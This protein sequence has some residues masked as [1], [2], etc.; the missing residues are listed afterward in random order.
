MAWHGQA[1]TGQ[2]GQGKGCQYSRR[3]IGNGGPP[4]ALTHGD[5]KPHTMKS[6]TYTVRGTTPLLMHS[7][8]LAN[9]FDPL[10]V[11]LKTLT[12]RRNK[13]QDDLL[14]IARIEWLGGLYHDESGIF[15]P[16]YNVLAAL[17]GGGKMR[18]L[19]TAIKRGALVQEDKVPVE[20]TGPKNPDEL[21]KNKAFVDIRSVK[22]G[23]AKV[24][25]CRPKF[26]DWKITFTLL[27]A[28]DTL[29]KSDLDL[30]VQ[31]TGA[32][33]GIGDYRPRF[34]RFEVVR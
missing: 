26:A 27:Y 6:V 18:K 14:E 23:T 17:V 15:L 20:Y 28:N 34:G 19:G 32:M 10:T 8:R 1:R 5:E 9:P 12:K 3:P 4:R 22:V 31:D 2:A 33:I 16:G 29:Q 11:E 30:V 25:R 21:F 24:T 13:T 7:E